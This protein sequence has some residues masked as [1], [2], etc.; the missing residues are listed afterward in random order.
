MLKAVAAES[1]DDEEAFDLERWTDDWH[2]IGGHLVESRPRVRD[3]GLGEGGQPLHRSSCDLLNKLPT[4]GQVITRGF[5]R[6]RHSEKNPSA[7]AMKIERRLEIDD[8]DFRSR[9]T[10][11]GRDRFS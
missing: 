5:V 4:N 10:G 6:I 2:G 8:H 7:F 9:H 11:A 1:G 3:S